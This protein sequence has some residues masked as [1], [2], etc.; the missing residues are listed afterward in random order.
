MNLRAEE[1]GQKIGERSASVRTKLISR[2]PKS[3]RQLGEDSLRWR[4][5]RPNRRYASSIYIES[6]EGLI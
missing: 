2:T 6:A 4:R 3:G 5:S 1:K